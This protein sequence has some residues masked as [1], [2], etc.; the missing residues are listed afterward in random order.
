M[1][2]SLRGGKLNRVDYFDPKTIE[3]IAEDLASGETS[4]VDEHKFNR[5]LKQYGL[6]DEEVEILV[7]KFIDNFSM[8]DIAKKYGFTSRQT[9]WYFYRRTLRRLNNN[10]FKNMVKDEQ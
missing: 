8:A 2:P 9:A 6:I 3:R 1:L 4:S 10:Y 7:A 5:L